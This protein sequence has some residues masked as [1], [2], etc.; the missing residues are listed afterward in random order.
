MFCNAIRAGI[1]RSVASGALSITVA[2]ALG[3]ALFAG[4]AHA[5]EVV[6]ASTAENPKRKLADFEGKCPLETSKACPDTTSSDRSSC[7]MLVMDV[8]VESC[9]PVAQGQLAGLSEC[10]TALK[11][12]TD[13]SKSCVHMRRLAIARH[14]ACVAQDDSTEA[15]S[16]SVRFKSKACAA[17]PSGTK[18]PD[19]RAALEVLSPL[20][21]VAEDAEI[22]RAGLYAARALFEALSE[23]VRISFDVP[24]ATRS[25]HLQPSSPDGAILAHD[26]TA[27]GS[28]APGHYVARVEAEGYATKELKLSVLPDAGEGLCRTVPDNE[29]AL[30]ELKLESSV[31]G[32]G[33][34]YIQTK[35][36]NDL[37]ELGDVK[38]GLNTFQWSS[39]GM[40][41]VTVQVDGYEDYSVDVM[42]LH[43]FTRV[44]TVDLVR[45]EQDT[46]PVPPTLGLALLAH[47]VFD[48]TPAEPV[49]LAGSAL[50]VVPLGDAWEFQGGGQ[51]GRHFGG[52]RLGFASWSSFEAWSFG[53]EVGTT[54]LF[55]YG[56]PS[57][58]DTTLLAVH[59]GFL[60][61]SPR[62]GRFRAI[63][64]PSLEWVPW[65]SG[66]DRLYALVSGGLEG[67]L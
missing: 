13:P 12:A 9:I 52:P 56:T 29:P 5:T 3:S 6:C 55:P 62:F 65:G 49:G 48:F 34:A 39:D 16:A 67:R 28:L 26:G 22:D 21:C 58:E 33:K 24:R 59:G 30:L 64:G 46:T 15:G 25:I 10:L 50:M 14:L 7:C 47:G 53:G 19:F 54:L 43:G 1:R 11:H 51:F 20:R 57:G 2:M 41:H 31:A 36:D 18:L 17:A 32:A 37:N 35:G 8:E 61:A 44:V 38:G 45:R 23:P 63:V 42:L 60:L 66:Y 40:C 27:S 4:P